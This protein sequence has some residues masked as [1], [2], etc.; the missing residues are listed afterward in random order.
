MIYIKNAAS[1]SFYAITCGIFSFS[2]IKRKANAAI[3]LK[4]HLLLNSTFV[5]YLFDDLRFAAAV[6]R[7]YSAYPVYTAAR[8][9]LAF[10]PLIDKAFVT[11]NV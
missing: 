8:S 6:N 9:A 3:L 2:A 11:S 4:K 1:Y 10:V 5:A 7:E